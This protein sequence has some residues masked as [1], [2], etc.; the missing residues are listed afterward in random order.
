MNQEEREPLDTRAMLENA[1]IETLSSNT[2]LGK[3]IKKQQ[4]S[5]EIEATATKKSNV[6]YN[7]ESVLLDLYDT[8]DNL[9]ETYTKIGRNTP[10]TSSP[11]PG[12]G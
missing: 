12:R 4:E 10:A 3:A 6:N 5:N 7:T 9:I 11:G 2:K 1:F 8:R